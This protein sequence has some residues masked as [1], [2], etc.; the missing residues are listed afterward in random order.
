ML[1]FWHRLNPILLNMYADP[2]NEYSIPYYWG[3]Y[4]IGYDQD[5]FKNGPPASKMVY[6]I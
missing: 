4:G 5:L 1:T 2:A 6:S 3:V